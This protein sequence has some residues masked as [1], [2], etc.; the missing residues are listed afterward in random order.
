MILRDVMADSPAD[1][2][3]GQDAGYSFGLLSIQAAKA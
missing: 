3:I 1:V 2:D